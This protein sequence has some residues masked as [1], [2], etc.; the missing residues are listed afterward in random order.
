M[1]CPK[2]QFANPSDS[3]FCKECGAQLFPP[4]EISA[5]TETLEA[6]KEELTRGT[7]FAKRYEIIEE[8]GK[9]GM[10]KVYRVED[11][12]IKE[13]IALKLIKPEIASNKRTIERFSNELKMARKIAHR[14]VGRMYHLSEHE[15][16]H[17]I[18]MEYV[19]GEDLK[20]FIRR[21]KQLAIGKAI[22]IAKQVSEGLAEAHRQGVIHRDLKPSNIMIDRDGNAKIMDFGIARSLEAKGITAEG[23]IIGTPEYMSPE[24]AE[25]KEIDHRSDIYSLGVILY[26]MVTGRIPFEGD[27]PLAIAMKHKS[28]SPQDPKQLNSQI[29]EDL[30]IVILKCL[31][32]D[33]QKRYQSAEDVRSELERIE[34]GLP[35]TER[36]IPKRKAITSKE[37]TLTFGLKKLFIPALAIIALAIIGIFLWQLLSHKEVVSQLPSKLS[38]AVLPFE[39]LSPLKDQ[40]YLCDGLADEIIYRLNKVEDIWIPARTS[41]FSFKGK[42]L[43]IQEIGSRLN[44]ETVL[45]G[46]LRKAE[47]KLRITVQLVKAADNHPIWSEMY[48]RVEGDIFELQDEIS[49]AVLDNLK[50]KVLDEEKA[51]LTIRDTRNTEAYNLYLRARY[52]WNM[53]TWPHYRKAIEYFKQAIAIEPLYAQAFA[54]IA[55]SYNLLGYQGAMPPK[56]AYSKAR[57]YA[58]KAL[59]LN[60][61]I[62]EPFVALA[63]INM[64]YDWDWKSAEENFKQALRLNP[65]S[66]HAHCL[67]AEFLTIFGRCDEA[68]KAANKAVELDPVG[69]SSLGWR[70]FIFYTCRRYDAALESITKNLELDPE[71]VLR[72]FYLGLV[73]LQKSLHKEALAAIRKSTELGLNRCWL[74]YAYGIAGEKEKARAILEEINKISQ[75]S[76]VLPIAYIIVY[77]GLGEMDK[78]YEY[79]EKG[80][81]ERDSY[82]TL[83]NVDPIF[84]PL[85]SDPRFTPFTKKMGLE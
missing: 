7:I 85:R 83:L 2:C 28:E 47:N 45:E 24:Q 68:I 21:S 14:N 23:L 77:M 18:T 66:P 6:P 60:E 51:K 31:E 10:G 48:E 8:L 82:L 73:Y 75:E 25:A 5:P 80:Y 17:Y 30:N 13:E 36:V 26:E 63:T 4:E 62:A 29:T 59:G 22:S 33:Q 12:R 58:I 64:Y 42:G 54:G 9:G 55:D 61:A 46:T 76:Y 34:E 84:D 41:S 32:K 78:V 50:I 37:I 39:D 65:N 35:S 72:Y 71:G 3:K 53:H 16:T 67:F 38:I 40:E 81:E 57:E 15:G 27:T 11:K 52:H 74:G 56:E 19:P 43:N 69:L 79:L 49:L 1:K 44:V 20:S 70:D